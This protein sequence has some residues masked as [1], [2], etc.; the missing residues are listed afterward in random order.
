MS[1]KDQISAMLDELMGTSRN[2]EASKS[3]LRFDDR[4][5]CRAFLLGCCPYVILAAT[6]ADMGNCNKVHDLALKAD[7]E[8]ALLKRKDYNFEYDALELIE[9]FITESDRRKEI[10]KIRLKENQEELGEEA[11]KKMKKITEIEEEI[12]KL[13]LKVEEYGTNGDVDNSLKTM[14]EIDELRKKK[15]ELEGVFNTSMPAS[16]YQQQ[17][18]RICDI[19][20]ASLGIHDNDRRLV[21]HFGG[22]LHL[23]FITIREKLEELKN[24]VKELRELR[25]TAR[26]SEKSRRSRS[27]ERKTR[28]RTRSRSRTYDSKRIKSSSSDYKYRKHHHQRHKTESSRYDRRNRSRSR[29]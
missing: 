8:K 14:E 7:Y 25:R 10:A 26:E 9:A 27:R 11:A 20:S 1:A 23:G 3:S 13:L 22:K 19:C 24:K 15:T 6:K 29:S 5:V 18:L 17:K 28:S 2:G 16:A 4:S 12:V 21:D